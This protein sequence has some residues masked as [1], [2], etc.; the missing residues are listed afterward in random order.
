L[1]LLGFNFLISSAV[2]DLVIPV[3]KVNWFQSVI[4]A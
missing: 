4:N 1:L 3:C 2:V